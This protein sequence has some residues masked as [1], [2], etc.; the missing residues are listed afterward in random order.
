[1]KAR[2]QHVVVL[3]S[4]GQRFFYIIQTLQTAFLITSLDESQVEVEECATVKARVRPDDCLRLAREWKPCIMRGFEPQYKEVA[5]GP[6][7]WKIR[8][9]YGMDKSL[10]GVISLRAFLTSEIPKLFT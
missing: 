4:R 2:G 6:L 8:S 7:M 3:E 1:M 5:H 10:C 9:N